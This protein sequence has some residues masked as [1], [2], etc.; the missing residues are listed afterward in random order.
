MSEV[1]IG[2]GYFRPS[3][4][5]K[6]TRDYIPLDPVGDY[7]FGL[8]HIGFHYK[9]TFVFGGGQA[10]DLLLLFQKNVADETLI[11][12]PTCRSHEVQGNSY[13]SLGVKSWECNNPL[14]P[15]RSKFN[16][17]KRYSFLQLLKQEAIEDDFSQIPVKS[18]RSWGKDVQP[19]EAVADI[20]PMIIRHYTLAGDGVA[21]V[22]TVDVPSLGRDLKVLSVEEYLAPGEVGEPIE[23][24]LSSAYFSRFLVRRAGEPLKEFRQARIGSAALA[25]HGDSEKVLR[26]LREES[27][28]GA[29]TSPPY[30]NA[31]EYSQ[32][33]NV[34]CYMYDMY[35]NAAEV[36]RVLKPGGYYL[37]N[38][39]DYFDNEN[40]IALSAMGDK[41][42]ILSAYCVRAFEECGFRT[43]GNVVWDKGEI[44]GKRAFNGGNFSPYYQ[45]PLNCWE[46]ILVF[47]K[48]GAQ[49]E[50]TESLPDFLRAKPVIKMVRGENRH[51]HTAPFPEAVPNLL[52]ERLPHGSIVLDPYGGSM[53]TARAAERSG[54]AS[55][56]IEQDPHYFDLGVRLIGEATRQFHLV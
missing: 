20:L 22:G 45:A 14:C 53:T 12:C 10:S 7:K 44:E 42:M 6:S 4:I 56:C 27:V 8:A 2:N 55:I 40:N 11:P 21:A 15:D 41:R 46:H 23:R 43:V 48:P 18:V 51:G 5:E 32:W 9:D 17:G 49:V 38:I 3:A 34:Y 33:D 36:F 13:S 52:L 47:R 24:E 35:N 16:R 29:V 39:F 50:L 19:S 26:T 37:F 31:R 1:K 28:D 54:H 30:Y 25:I